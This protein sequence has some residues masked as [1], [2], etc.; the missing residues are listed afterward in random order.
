VFRW[1]GR[2]KWGVSHNGFNRTGLSGPI[3]DAVTDDRTS[4]RSAVTLSTS[5]N[6]DILSKLSE[7]YELV[8]SSGAGYK[9]ICV[10]DHLVDLY[11]LSKG[12]TFKWD[13]CA[14]HAILL[15]QGGGIVDFQTA[16]GDVQNI[17]ESREMLEAYQ[18]KYHVRNTAFSSD[19]VD[20][21]ANINGII[22]YSDGDKLVDVLEYLSKAI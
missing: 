22:A 4:K 10:A 3:P 16:L 9:L 11:F 1:T 21:W 8:Y 14:P 12:S 7:K 5:E 15:A 18:L 6:K 20:C 13:T 2:Y 19:S 17:R